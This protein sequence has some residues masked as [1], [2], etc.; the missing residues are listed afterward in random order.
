MLDLRYSQQYYQ[1]YYYFLGHGTMWF[2]SEP[3][4]DYMAAYLRRHYS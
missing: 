1:E 4:E 3:Q 2:S